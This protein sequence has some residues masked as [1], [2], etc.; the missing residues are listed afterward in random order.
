MSIPTHFF[1][2]KFADYNSCSVVLKSYQNVRESEFTRVKSFDLSF[3]DASG[4]MICFNLPTTLNLS[5]SRNVFGL[6]FVRETSFNDPSSSWTSSKKRKT[7]KAGN[8][9]ASLKKSSSEVCNLLFAEKSTSLFYP[10]PGYPSMIK[11]RYCISCLDITYVS[12]SF[13]LIS[14]C[15][16]KKHSVQTRVHTE[17]FILLT[18]TFWCLL[19]EYMAYTSEWKEPSEGRQS[20]AARMMFAKVKEH[21]Y[22]TLLMF[23]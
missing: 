7:S 19:V 23:A 17:L 16:H 14:G 18:F 3:L 5:V 10:F 2:W 4:Q 15:R 12:C 1:L 20:C 11:H 21:L 13:L 22:H 6:D 8:Q 9:K